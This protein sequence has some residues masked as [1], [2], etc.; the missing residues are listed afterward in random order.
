VIDE[1]ELRRRGV[2]IRVGDPE[3]YI[4]FEDGTAFAQFLDEGR[5]HARLQR[6]LRSHPPAAAPR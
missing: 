4:P 6:A 1:L 2:R 5:T 3:L